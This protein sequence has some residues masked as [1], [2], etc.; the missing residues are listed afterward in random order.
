MKIR[1][2]LTISKIFL[3]L[4]L[5]IYAFFVS[6]AQK[7]EKLSETPPQISALEAIRRNAVA[8]S[9][10]DKMQAGENLKNH[11]WEIE[12][13]FNSIGISPSKKDG[14]QTTVMF[15][16]EKKPEIQIS[17]T[18]YYSA[19]DAKFPLTLMV[20]QGT[21]KE[22]NGGFCGDEGK[23]VYGRRGFISLN[24]KKENYFVYVTCDSEQT[25][26]RFADYILK[27][28]EK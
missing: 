16:K 4:S 18:E 28:I 19:D 21:A 8:N 25:A 12:R 6:Y 20:S 17:L 9:F 23:K 13:A 22:C 7:I 11:N 14:K 26:M 24:F 5:L 3:G 27:A 15:F 10:Y 1:Y 2:I